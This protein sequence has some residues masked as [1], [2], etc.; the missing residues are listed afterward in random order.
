MINIYFPLHPGFNVLTSPPRIL[1][2]FQ[3]KYKKTQQFIKIA[4]W[5]VEAP[6]HEIKQYKY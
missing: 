3:K 2:H 4:Y 6:K 1:R 5:N